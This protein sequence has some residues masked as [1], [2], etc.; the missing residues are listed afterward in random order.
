MHRL[1]LRVLPA[2]F[3]SGTHLFYVDHNIM[4]RFIDIDSS[5]NFI[6]QQLQQQLDRYHNV[7]MACYVVD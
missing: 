6:L 1:P 5:P 3:I 2:S 4:Q 7:D